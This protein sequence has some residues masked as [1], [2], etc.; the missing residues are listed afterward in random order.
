MSLQII[1]TNHDYMELIYKEVVKSNQILEN[2]IYQ[3]IIDQYNDFKKTP[4]FMDDDMVI[5]LWSLDYASNMNVDDK[6]LLFTKY[7]HTKLFTKLPEIASTNCYYSYDDFVEEESD[8]LD[9]YI[10]AYI[11]QNDV[12]LP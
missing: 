10:I 7:G 3:V 2:K 11:I 4:D 6:N 9:M 12:I 8:D 1:D 5:G